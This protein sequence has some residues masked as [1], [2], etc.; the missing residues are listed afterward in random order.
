VSERPD[1]LGSLR[2]ALAAFGEE[3]AAKLLATAR[4]EALARARSILTTGMTRALLDAAG[5]HLGTPRAHSGAP[6]PSPAPDTGSSALYV[7]GVAPAADP[8]LESALGGSGVADADPFALREGELAAIA[9][10][11][12]L[13]EFDEAP[14]REN[15]NDVGWLERVARAHE[16]VLERARGI[17][18]VVPFRL[19][20]MYR[21][22]GHVREMLAREAPV[23]RNALARLHG[24]TEWG[25]KVIAE[26]GALARALEDATDEKLDGLPAGVAYLRR[27]GRQARAREE[28][29]ELAARWAT[30]IH[31]E[32]AARAEE[33]LL[34]PLQN[35]EVSGHTGDMLLNGAYLVADA[36]LAA[37]REGCK[38][39]TAEFAERAVSVELTGPWPPYNFVQSSVDAAR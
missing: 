1:E 29:G 9:S 32:L 10:A 39:L 35:P 14:L 3:H 5:T 7:Y 31:D 18:T 23:F 6:G 12:P 37:F 13:A 16:G 30:D 2:E 27:R 36:E 28:L 25:V 33:A 11:V 21:D 17:T 24:K 22:A 8:K 19:C 34:S 15:L 20:T 26:P 38:R 4:E